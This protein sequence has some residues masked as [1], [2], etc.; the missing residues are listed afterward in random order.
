M[1]TKSLLEERCKG[2]IYHMLSTLVLKNEVFDKLRVVR[3]RLV[4]I[5]RSMRNAIERSQQR[6]EI[7]QER[8]KSELENMIEFYLDKATNTKNKDKRK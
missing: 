2:Y 7:L 3:Q 1:S 6:K 4:F 5:A 8:F